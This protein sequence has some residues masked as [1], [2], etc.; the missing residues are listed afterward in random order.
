[1]RSKKIE[2]ANVVITAG[3]KEFLDLFADHFWPYLRDTSIPGRGETR[4]FR[5]N[6]LA[7]DFVGPAGFPCLHGRL[8]RLMTLQAEQQFDDEKNRLVPS[9]ESISSAPSAYFLISLADHKLAFLP[10]SKRRPPIIKDLEHCFEYIIFEDWRTRRKNLKADKLKKE[11]RQRVPRGHAE[12]WGQE[13]DRLWP[14]PEI[15][16]TP[17]PASMELKKRLALYNLLSSIE[18]KPLKTN[19][20]IPDENEQFLRQY[21]G[22]KTKI[23]ST[24]DKIVLSNTKDGLAKDA[25]ES[26]INT[27]SDGNYQVKLKGKDKRGHPI[28][29][30]LENMRIQMAYS[31]AKGELL[32]DRAF[33]LLDALVTALKE[34][35][36]S[37][38]K[39]GLGQSP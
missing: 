29:D 20:E 23:R 31:E 24:N 22:L 39:N 3:D 30:D 7:L 4:S 1:M 8:I 16:I 12:I 37:G 15:R 28:Q 32:K 36:V 2:L 14:R 34:N 26:F 33:K 13:I 27:A 10:E 18:I 35:F 6:D 11:G 21:A 25:A 17:L 38:R 9:Q 19:N 5:F